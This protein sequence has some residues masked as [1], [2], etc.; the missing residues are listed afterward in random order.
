MTP[1]EILQSLRIETVPWRARA[2]AT[3][4]SAD[5]SLAG[6][7]RARQS[8]AGR[9]A[10]LTRGAVL[11]LCD[12]FAL[13]AAALL[14][15]SGW[16]AA[17]Y[18]LAVLVVLNVRGCQR[19]RV[20]LRASDEVPRLAASAVLPILLFLPWT[21]SPGQLARLCVVS[22]GLI[23]TMRA[24][25]Y[26]VLRAARW[27]GWLIEPALVV[28]TGQLGVE[29]GELLLEH[30]DLGLR[31]VGFVDSLPPAPESSLPLLGELSELPDVVS[32]HRVRRVIV[33]FADRSGADADLVSILRASP[34]LP[35]EVCVVPRAYELAAAIPKGR[36]DEI[37]G[38]PLIPL[39]RSGL[40]WSGRV[41]KRAF[42][43]IV[44]TTL[45]VTL[46]PAF[47]VLMAGVLLCSGRPVL[48]RQARVTRSGRIIKIAKLRTMT[49]EDSDS[50]WTVPPGECSALSRWLRASHLDELP[51]L[52]N[53]I[54]GE[55]SLVG[56]RPERPYFASQFAE[57]V[58]RYE[59]RHRTHGGMTGW[60][61]VHG[62]TGDTS[63]A[64]RAR[65]DNHYIEHWSLWM[66]LVILARTLA[67]PLIG[68]RRARRSRARR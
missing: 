26:A 29:V 18:A 43:L 62:L 39:R 22:V 37:W 42:D 56:P 20:C 68:V 7:H 23:V 2:A 57:V 3:A 9:L 48:F 55:M 30:R 33:C 65:F 67:E 60:A 35:A 17:A 10:V 41:A 11:P 32:R 54:R 50:Q 16:P 15:G 36:L 38:I 28:G 45:L 44:G 4:P 52:L 27:R 14:A 46:A 59:D 49:C 34:S 51:Q 47:L 6:R 25:S 12:G 66:D 19:L 13:A 63:I 64:E 21:K 61:Q 5:T 24:A 31:P 8:A 1:R 40:R 58:P 53:V